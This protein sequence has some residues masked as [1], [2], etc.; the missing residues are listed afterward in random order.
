MRLKTEQN[1]ATMEKRISKAAHVALGIPSRHICADFEHGQWWI[2]NLRSGAQWSVVDA[3]G[4]LAV[5]GFD[6]EQ[7][8]EGDQ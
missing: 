7:V 3:E 2:T 4:G 6:F 5:D 1:T 8:T